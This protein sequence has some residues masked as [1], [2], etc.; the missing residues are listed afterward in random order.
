MTLLA[1]T[2]G[3]IDIKKIYFQTQDEAYKK[4][5]AAILEF[6]VVLAIDGVAFMNSVACTKILGREH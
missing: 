2:Y 6:V 4:S 5:L 3:G 1:S